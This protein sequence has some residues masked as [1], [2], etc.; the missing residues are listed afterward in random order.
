[1]KR[2]KFVGSAAGAALLAGCRSDPT[3]GR[4]R[5]AEVRL[6]GSSL[7]EWRDRYRK[8]LFDVVLPFWDRHGV[9]HERGGILHALDRKSVV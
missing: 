5:P 4:S 7:A 6:A 1:M 3:A 8:E 2:R 9:D